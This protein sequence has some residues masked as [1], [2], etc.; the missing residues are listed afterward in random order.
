MDSWVAKGYKK[1]LGEVLDEWRNDF[2]DETKFKATW[3]RLM[4][5]DARATSLRGYMIQKF[6]IDKE[7]KPKEKPNTP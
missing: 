6:A 5:L 2:A 1:I 3:E 7:G 4:D